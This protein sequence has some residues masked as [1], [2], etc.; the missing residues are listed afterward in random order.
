MVLAVA[1]NGCESR[2]VSY[3]IN[4]ISK[5]VIGDIIH[6]V[7]YNFISTTVALTVMISVLGFWGV[8]SQGAHI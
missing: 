5:P 2:A 1:I 3:A 8:I 6:R 4:I 7:N